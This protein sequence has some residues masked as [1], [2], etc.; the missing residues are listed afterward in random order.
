LLGKRETLE[1]L[2]REGRAVIFVDGLD[3]IGNLMIPRKLRDAVHDGMSQYQSVRWVLT[4]RIVGYDQVPF[5][6]ATA[7]ATGNG[8]KR[9]TPEN[10]KNDSVADVVYLAPFTSHQIRE[11]ATKWYDRHES[12]PNLAP[13][14]AEAFVKAINDNAGTK[15]LAPVPYLLTLMALIHRKAASLP[16][17]RTDLYDR[18]RAARG[19]PGRV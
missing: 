16:H 19:S 1:A 8:R 18:I 2:M 6:V 5:H 15:R 14:R 3:E 13:E 10:L 4:S 9:I 7:H 11:F 17:G 12:D